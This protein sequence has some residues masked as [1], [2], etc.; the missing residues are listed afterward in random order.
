[1]KRPPGR[2]TPPLR[3]KTTGLLASSA[4]AAK[5]PDV[6]NGTTSGRMS[7]VWLVD[8]AF[9]LLAPSPPNC[10]AVSNSAARIHVYQRDPVLPGRNGFEPGVSA[11][12]DAVATSINEKLSQRDSDLA[13]QVNRVAKAGIQ[14]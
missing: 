1:M 14:L 3:C 10:D 6:D 13:P 8:S 9:R 4:P 11:L 7:C 2:G 12:A 5:L